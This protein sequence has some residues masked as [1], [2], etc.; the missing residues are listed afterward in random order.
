MEKYTFDKNKLPMPV[1]KNHKDWEGI[2]YNA[3]ELAFKNVDYIQKE[4]WKPQLTCM[5]GIN[6]V[7]QWDSC[8]MTFITNYSNG[9]LDA[10]NNLDNLY[11]LRR[12]DDGFMAMAYYVDTEAEAYPGRINP[13]L[14]AW[15]EWEH[16]LVT[17]DSSRFA[18][19]LPALEGLYSFI[20]N[21]RRRNCGLYWFEDPGSSGMDNSPRGGYE[22]KTLNGSDVCFIDL[23]CQQAMSAKYISFMSEHIN[24]LDKAE[25]YRSEYERICSLINKYHWS[26]KAGFYF[27][28]FARDSKEK[29]VKLINTKTAAA[30]WTLVSG[31]AEE[32]RKRSVIDHMFNPDEFY[33]PIPFASLSRDDLNYDKNGGYWLG[34]VWAPT[35][36]AAIRGL[37]ECG[38]EE[39]ARESAIK[40]LNAICEVNKNPLF[41]SIW[42]AYSPEELRPATTE[43]GDVCRM[44]FIG[45]SGIA[46][47]TLLIE[48]I[49]GLRFN[50]KT[51]TIH[52]SVPREEC[53]L[54]NMQFNGSIVSVECTKYQNFRGKTEISVTTEKPFT[55]CVRVNY[56]FEDVIINVPKGKHTYMI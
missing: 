22:I 25:F 20:E 30:F 31:V 7:W 48:N 32:E 38:Y 14:M 6:I 35:N 55:L 44:D 41:G 40:Y 24:E 49:I 13:P 18:Q 27:D 45:W 12:E 10:F 53:G 43:A 51:N 4:N 34:S 39:L 33:T 15:A 54:R 37:C 50:A 46:P 3:W 11:R 19:V 29:R 1:L 42:E 52:F 16:F 17:G 47:I 28:F 56:M 23:A 9:T 2:Y 36:F 8:I 5:P 21:N 26:D